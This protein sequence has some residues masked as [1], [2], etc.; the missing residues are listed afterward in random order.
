MIKTNLKSQIVEKF[1]LEICN[2]KGDINRNLLGKK[3]FKNP[4]LLESLN[5]IIHP[6][7]T[8]AFN[9]FKFKHK[10]SPIIIK[11]AAILI[12]SGAYKLCDTI[13]LIKAPKHIR[14]SRVKRRDGI[15]DSDVLNR[16]KNQWS[17]IKYVKF[18][19]YIIE[20]VSLDI[21]YKN[22]QEIFEKIKSNF[23]EKLKYFNLKFKRD[24]TISTSNLR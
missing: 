21:M 1:G 19:V 8:K 22:D 17:D 20:N 23:F 12:E 24:N 9:D 4:K 14:I 3:V 5:N 15:S 10:E 7:V 18:A 16:M 6:E 11:E 13:I 2:S